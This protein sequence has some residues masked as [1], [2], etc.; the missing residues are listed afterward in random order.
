MKKG[1]LI[2]LLTVIICR[3][4]F[5]EGTGQMIETN[6]DV[7]I[8][9]LFTGFAREK[10]MVHLKMGGFSMTLARA[11][12]IDTKGVSSIEVYSFS[13]CSREIRNKFNAAIKNLKDKS[14]E[15]LVSTSENGERTKVFLKIKDDRIREI[16]VVTGG[17]DPALIKI[18]GKIKPDDVKGVIA[19]N[20]K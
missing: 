2:A 9:Q 12:F 13:E 17:N 20:K 19:K 6:Y 3:N 10:N 1:I 4:G 15:T 8:E 5:S 11:F 7:T 16:V 18:K 14:Y